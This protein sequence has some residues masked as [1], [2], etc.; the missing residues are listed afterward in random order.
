MK[1][2]GLVA[3]SGN[4][5]GIFKMAANRN[6]GL[7]IENLDT[8]K[9]QFASTRQ[10]NF[11]PLESIG[12]FTNDGD[13]V[14]LDKVFATM[15]EQLEENPP[16]PPKSSTIELRDYFS[17][18]LPNHDE[19]R[20]Y[21]RD[22]RRVLKWFTFLNERDLLVEEEEEETATDAVEDTEEK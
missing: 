17:K 20:V 15:L 6:N 3:V 12:I 13:S 5:N 16:I 22:I 14:D 10:N 4:V 18:V 2:E 8:G 7:I 1:L 21:P 11:T 19:E 9:R